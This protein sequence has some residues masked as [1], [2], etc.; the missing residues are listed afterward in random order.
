MSIGRAENLAMTTTALRS[1]VALGFSRSDIVDVIESMSPG[2][3]YK[4]MTTFADHRLGQDVYHVPYGE[5]LLYVKFQADI[6]TEFK[7]M[8][9]KEKD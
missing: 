8:S 2:M 6:V 9:F 4:S 3:F 5:W 7:I 1:A